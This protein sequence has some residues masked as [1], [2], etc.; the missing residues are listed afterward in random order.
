MAIRKP[1]PSR[2]APRAPLNEIELFR[3]E[4][5]WKGVIQILGEVVK[6]GFIL[7]LALSVIRTVA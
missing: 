1:R 4:R 7:V 6:I 3:A 5:G 2:L